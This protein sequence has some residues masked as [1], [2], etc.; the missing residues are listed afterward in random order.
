MGAQGLMGSYDAVVVGAGPNGLTAACV[1]AQAGWRVLLVEACDTVGGGVSSAALTLPGFTHDLGS[2]VH[3]FGVASPAFRALELERYGL[4]W[5]HPSA[6]LAHPLDGGRAALLQRSVTATAAG[7]GR[8]G[9]AYHRLMAPLA[10]WWERIQPTVLDPLRFPP[11]PF[12]AAR[13]GLRALWPITLLARALF[14]GD[15]APA[16]LAGLGAHSFL[17]L[18]APL[19]AAPA[20]VIG[21]LGHAV[22]WPVPQ[23]GAQAIANALVACLKAHGGEVRTG[24]RVAHMEELP[25]ARA[26]LFDLTP[27]Q[28]VSVAGDRLPAAYRR[29]LE[30]FRY[31]PGVFKLDYALDGPIPWAAPECAR[32]ITVHLGGTLGEIADAERAPHR[33]EHAARPYV[34]LSQPTLFDPT[35]APPGRHIAWAYC[36]VPAGSTVDMTDAI[37]AQIERFAPGFRERVAGRSAMNCADMERWN[38]NLIG[39][40]ISGGLPDWRQ[41][42]ARPTLSARPQRTPAP[43]IYL[44][45]SSTTPGPGVHGMCGYHAAR[46]ALKDVQER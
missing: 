5:V 38:A 39:G 27:R 30:R 46:A 6:P 44:C 14:R 12:A 11:H 35:R 4:R 37:E 33:G 17:P 3:P 40:A 2:A 22:G 1:L 18:E 7:L 36:H 25:Q 43:G 21:A 41:L 23:G 31:G 29:R 24:W 45:S 16:L 13:F 8:D 9:A 28:L 10:R 20:L 42:F 32:A 15:A 19:T 34:L 26:Y